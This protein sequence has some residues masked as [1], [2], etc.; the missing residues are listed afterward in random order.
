L[1]FGLAS[2]K[3]NVLRRQIQLHTVVALLERIA[4]MVLAAIHDN[5]AAAFLWV[6][7]ARC[8]WVHLAC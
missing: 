7:V 1:V 5:Y 6:V 3:T 4:F 2:H 8:S